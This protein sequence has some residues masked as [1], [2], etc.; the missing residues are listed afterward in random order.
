MVSAMEAKHRIAAV[1]FY[2]YA[3]SL[4]AIAKNGSGIFWQITYES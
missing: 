3:R 4:T 2:V 1:L